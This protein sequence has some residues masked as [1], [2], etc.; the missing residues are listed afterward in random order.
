ME[1]H[2]AV[3]FCLAIGLLASARVCPAQVAPA[4]GDQQQLLDEVRRLRAEVQELRNQVNGGAAP[5]ARPANAVED[6]GATTAQMLRDADARSQM[7]D[8]SPMTAGYVSGKGFVVRS[9][10]GNFLLHPW[11]FVQVRNTT[12]YREHGKHGTQGD[13]E[14][15]FEVPR[16]KFILDGN[17][18]SKDLTYQ[19]IWATSD[20]TGNLGL[21]DAWAR[22]HF[23]GTSWAVRG[24]QI[25]DPFDH[26][27]II[28]ATRSMTPERSIV[29]NVFAN[30][31]GVVKGA[32]VSYGYDT[33]APVRAE[34]A[35]TSGT[36]NFD[37]T[38]QPFPTNPANWGA[39]GRVEW[40]LAGK[41]DDY[42]Q[43]T[44][45]GEKETL[46]VL[47]A[48]VDYTEAG[49]AGAFMHVVD[50][51]FDTPGGLSLYGAYLGRYTRHNGGAVGT[52]GG[53]SGGGPT[54]N[55]YDSTFR[56]MAGY[57]IDGHF[58]PF[59]RYEYLHFNRFEIPANAP[60]TVIHDV[61]VGFNYYF[62][63]HRAKFTAAASYLPN[64]SPIANTL[65]DLLVTQGGSEV[66]VQAQ[67]QLIL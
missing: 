59:A 20:T 62:L 67:F 43:F 52:N 3:G 47:G 4:A 28:Y 18:V 24:G 57:V 31:D 6:A 39:A 48:G 37:T 7:L 17:V 27:Q 16:M 38:F 34:V 46:L 30:A 49:D 40:K 61:T 29:N 5:A 25:R 35:I 60:H 10:D 51:Q 41:W 19:F 21:Q 53:L 8:M 26:E 65:G 12:N 63:S 45:L 64:G 11:A 9:D 15:G 55:T 50:A 22:Y 32:S 58:E 1:R 2:S 56:V 44:A 54:A 33:N 36:R 23:P 13:L 14:N 66:I 42:S